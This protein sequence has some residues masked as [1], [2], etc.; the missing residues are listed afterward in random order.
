MGHVF[1]LTRTWRN[2][3]NLFAIKSLTRMEPIGNIELPLQLF[4]RIML[5]NLSSSYRHI[6]LDYSVYFNMTKD[7]SCEMCSCKMTKYEKVV[8]EKFPLQI[9]H[10]RHV[11][12]SA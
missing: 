6:C 2:L 4:F 9:L 5:N 8:G 3:A 1:V 11:H 10:V 12:M 7:I